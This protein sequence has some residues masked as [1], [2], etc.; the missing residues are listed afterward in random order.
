MNAW[1]DDGHK[2]YND[3]QRL[4]VQCEGLGERIVSL[5]RRFAHLTLRVT[6]LEMRSKESDLILARHEEKYLH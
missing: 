1:L 3:L 6:A 2:L 5:D 4:A